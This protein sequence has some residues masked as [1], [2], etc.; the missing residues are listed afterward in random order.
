M[1]VLKTEKI[2]DIVNVVVGGSVFVTTMK[3]LRSV[4]DTRLAE[5]STNSQEFLPDQNVYFFDRNPEFFNFVLDFYRTGELHIPKHVCGA[6]IRNELEFWQIQ[7]ASIADCCVSNLF[8]FEDELE[9]TN[10]LRRQFETKSLEYTKEELERSKWNRTK[11]MLWCVLDKPSSSKLA[12]AYS[13]IYMI[14]VVITCMSFILSTHESFRT[15]INEKVKVNDSFSQPLYDYLLS[16]HH[17]PKIALL[18]STNLRPSLQYVSNICALFFMLELLLRFITCPKRREFFKNWLNVVDLIIVLSLLLTTIMTLVGGF[19]TTT[20]LLWLYVIG[21]SFIILRLFRL[22]RFA[23][24]FSGLKIV[25]L[26]LRASLKELGLLC[27]TFVITTSMFGALIFYAEFYTSTHLDNVPIGI[28]WAIVTLTT[29]GYGDYVPVT[30]PGYLVG[31][32]CAMCGLL[33]LSMPIAVIATNFN[34]YY[35]QNKIREKQLARK[36]DIFNKIKNLFKNRNVVNVIHL[37]PVHSATTPRT[38]E[39]QSANERGHDSENSITNGLVNSPR[40]M[41]A[42]FK[43]AAAK[44]LTQKQP[45]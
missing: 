27:L 17:N 37:D 33:L 5:I 41:N 38:R 30:T 19:Y 18:G 1:V 25:Y 40:R 36:R 16:Q 32:L 13:I 39:I 34:D 2:P 22:F 44:L 24:H 10:N 14:F 20:Y 35:S 26:A 45:D 12:K 7:P 28:W 6:A 3:T 15:N 31:A 43:Q 42:A 23:K 11:N 4:P 8:K 29:V 9:V 21:Q